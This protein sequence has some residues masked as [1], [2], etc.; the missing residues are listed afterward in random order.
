MPLNY[1]FYF[2]L[3]KEVAMFL[4]LSKIYVHHGAHSHILLMLMKKYSF[5]SLYPYQTV[6]FFH[7]PDYAFYRR[8]RLSEDIL[9]L[10]FPLLKRLLI[11]LSFSEIS[12]ALF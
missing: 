1:L 5:E 6:A 3:K 9:G 11:W 2:N 10:G 8:E 7:L 4:L 12:K